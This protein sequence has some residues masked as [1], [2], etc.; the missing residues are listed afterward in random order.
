M[1][2]LLRNQFRNHGKW[3]DAN[4]ELRKQEKSDEARS[5]DSLSRGVTAKGPTK[6]PQKSFK[7]PIEPIAK[8]HKK[9]DDDHTISDNQE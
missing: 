1:K 5:K 7:K 9:E 6:V 2:S 4:I 3:L 8:R